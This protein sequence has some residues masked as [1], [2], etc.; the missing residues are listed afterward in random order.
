M[1]LP[2]WFWLNIHTAHRT[3][4]LDLDRLEPPVPPR[5][6][7]ILTYVDQLD[8]NSEVGSKTHICKRVKL[9]NSPLQAQGVCEA[10]DTRLN[11]LI[12]VQV[13]HKGKE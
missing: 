8:E 3:A 9:T 11:L 6:N 5:T 10:K 12:D 1:N 4:G 13:V 2:T 7:V